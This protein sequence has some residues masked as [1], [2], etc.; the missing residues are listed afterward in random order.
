LMVI[1]IIPQNP[2]AGLFG[3]AL[4][5]YLGHQMRQT[6]LYIPLG[7]KPFIDAADGHV[8]LR[9]ICLP[10]AHEPP[11]DSSL[12]TLK[13]ILSLFPDQSPHIHAIHSG[14]CMPTVS[15]ELRS[16][17][18]WND[19]C[20]HNASPAKAIVEHA[21]ES[22]ADLIIM[23]TNGRD[24]LSQKIMGSITEQVLR[25]APCPVLAT[26]IGSARSG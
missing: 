9:N 16:G 3:T 17:L 18:K 4:A 20:R 1:G 2:I 15:D 19:C 24:T 14:S 11:A 21:C 10:V 12:R 6:T 25:S 7:S 23:S 26:A 5:N 22:N 8:T 13:Q